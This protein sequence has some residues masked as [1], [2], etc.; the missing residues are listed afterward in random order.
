[1]PIEITSRLEWKELIDEVDKDG[2]CQISLDE[3]KE[4]M[5]KLINNWINKNINSLNDVLLKKNFYENR[6]NIMCYYFN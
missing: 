3:F 4:M 6:K 1:M 2:D 5:R